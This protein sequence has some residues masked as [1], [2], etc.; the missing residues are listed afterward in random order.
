[1]PGL[2]TAVAL[3]GSAALAGGEQPVLGPLLGS[4]SILG[5]AATAA[6]REEGEP[7]RH[8]ALAYLQANRDLVAAFVRERLPRVGFDPPDAT[9]LAWLDFRAHW[10]RP[11]PAAV[12]LARARVRLAEGVEFGAPGFLRLAFGIRRE[13]LVAA[14]ARIAAAAAAPA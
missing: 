8:G 5:V 1:M 14:L 3:D 2:R 12:L 10:R 11:D 4:P 13:T 9:F 7:W 6:A